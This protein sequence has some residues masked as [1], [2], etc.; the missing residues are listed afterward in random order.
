MHFTPVRRERPA[1]AEEVPHA[2]MLMDVILLKS[3]YVV[4]FEHV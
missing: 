4:S 1:F 3:G 2:L